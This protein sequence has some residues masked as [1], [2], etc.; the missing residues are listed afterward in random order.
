M[1]PT[2]RITTNTN[3]DEYINIAE[4]A[5]D[6]GEAKFIVEVPDDAEEGDTL[7]VNGNPV[8]ITA[9]ILAEGYQGSA[10]VV[11]EEDLVVEAY[12]I[13]KAG[14]TSP[15]AT[16][17]EK[18]DIV[19]SSGKLNAPDGTTDSTPT[20]TVTKSPS[21]DGAEI[22]ATAVITILDANGNVVQVLDPVVVDESKT[23]S[24]T[25]TV[26][27][28]HGNYT[29]SMTITDKAGNSKTVTDVGSVNLEADPI[30]LY[31]LGYDLTHT[32]GPYNECG[33]KGHEVNYLTTT[34]N[35][36]IY[37]GFKG[38]DDKGNL[39]VSC[40]DGDFERDACDGDVVWE[41]NTGAGDDFI[42]VREDQNA[43]TVTKLGTGD[44]TYYIGGALDSH[45]VRA[46][47]D[48]DARAYVFGE[49]GDD[50]VVVGGNGDGKVTGWGVD[51]GRIFTGAGSDN[52]IIYGEVDDGGVIDLGSGKT[53]YANGYSEANSADT[54]ND[55][56]TL[57]ITKNL[58]NIGANDFGLIEGGDGQDNVVIDGAVNGRSEINLGENDNSLTAYKLQHNSQVTMGSGNDTLIIREDIDFNASVNL[59]DGNNII[60]VGEDV[61]DCAKI[62][63]GDGDD[64][65]DVARFIENNS[66][67]STG[68]GD[69][70]LTTEGLNNCARIEMGAGDDTLVIKSQFGVGSGSASVDMG[71]GD[72]VVTFG[73]S[74]M[75]GVIN[76]SKGNDTLVLTSDSSYSNI[77]SANFKGIENVDLKGKIDIEINY[78]DL[79]NDNVREGALFI[80]GDSS[81]K[82]DIDLD[83]SSGNW[84]KA[85]D[86]SRWHKSGSQ[87]IDGTVYDI[88]HHTDAGNNY[89]NDLYIEQG[90]AVI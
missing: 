12:I 24:V 14:N 4:L 53:K 67:V 46:Q 47:Y 59:G 18:V 66:F 83:T 33:K 15:V 34:I 79:L 54:A 71:W 3:G 61:E 77:S 5:A 55:V 39:I 29:A 68:R 16:D 70:T 75:D 48:G 58:G 30:F 80:K 87:D 8:I 28:A 44:D 9:A 31:H 21:T 89:S 86:T 27:L 19:I 65:I 90:V 32:A 26:P 57:R 49:D 50:T 56:N 2:V 23:F 1:A 6:G 73:G 78:K 88:Y 13:D 84:F 10:P 64:V 51:G 41:M 37:I 42:Y 72:D 69:D 62:I 52:V 81:N 85:A 45:L 7:V 25:P 36:E 20:I 38:F 74:H 17:S 35:D 60:K 11:H 22:G 82:V 63:T 43:Y 76:G 40:N